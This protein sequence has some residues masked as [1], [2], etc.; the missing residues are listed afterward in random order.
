M[1]G[2]YPGLMTIAAVVLGV[3]DVVLAVVALGVGALALTRRLPRN[4]FV[5]IRTP[6]TLRSDDAFRVA[7]VV[8]GPGFLGA[9]IIAALGAVIGLAAG[10]VTGL[11]FAAVALVAAVVI[12]GAA[13]SFGLR[14]AARVPDA[15]DEE[16][17]CGGGACGSCVLAGQCGTTGPAAQC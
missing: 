6:L 16:S 14:A 17:S 15:D 13:A 5:G 8:A 7:H 2:S 1:E 3:V 4:R 10:S 12:G 11:V 9:G